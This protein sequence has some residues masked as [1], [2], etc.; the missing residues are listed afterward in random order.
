MKKIYLGALTLAICSAGIAQNAQSNL[1][2]MKKD[3]SL[4]SNVRPVAHATNDERAFVIWSDDFSSAA[5]WTLTNTSTPALDFSLETNTAIIPVADLSPMASTSA[6]NGFLFINS[7]GIAGN[8]DGDG[9]PTVV[10]ATTVTAIDCSGEPNVVLSFEQ[11]YR[12]W[13]EAREVRVSGDNGATWTTYEL[14]TF[15]DYPGAQNTDNPQVE[16]IDISPVAGGQSQVL[17]QFYYNDNDFWG[18][19]WAVDD[20]K[21]SRT[22]DNDLKI[23]ESFFGS[24]GTYGLQLP[25]H[26]IPDEQIAPVDFAA[27]ISNIGVNSQ[28]NS[29]LSVDVN[30]GASILT[31][32]AVT[33]NPAST[34]SLFTTTNFTPAAI[35][36]YSVE[37]TVTSADFTDSD[38]ANNTEAFAIEVTDFMYARDNGTV[39]SGSYNSGDGFEIG[40]VFDIF[41]NQTLWAIDANIASNSNTDIEVSVALYFVEPSDGSYIFMEESD[42]LAVSVDQTNGNEVSIKLNS[43]QELTAGNS[44]V[45]VLRSLG[46]GGATNDLV[47][48]TAQ[49][50]PDQTTAY[51]D[52]TDW[53]YTTA[54]P[55]VRMNFDPTLGVN[56]AVSYSTTVNAY[57]NP[58]NNNVN[59]NYS[60]SEASGVAISV[61]TI[62]GEIVFVND[63]GTVNAGEYTENINASNLANGVY[64]YTLTVNGNEITKKLVISK[65]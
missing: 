14:T 64:F 52:G 19:Y 65:K 51:F 26:M 53:F 56:E 25:Y 60:L 59:I 15:T 38:M 61:A 41:T 2:P 10:E 54:T 34:D 4:P 18:W 45:A 48:A 40:N 28:T 55:M 46:D 44:Y 1:K 24:M 30:A 8:S 29:S 27:I 22:E 17:V 33:I 57:P 39:V 6:A 11:N 50:A 7:D 47:C 43:P 63:M 20:V 9:T 31:S 21:I 16:T 36:V 58:A 5:T 3:I 62:T 12:W 13:Q 23:N 37:Y 42:L 49:N 35:G 32:A